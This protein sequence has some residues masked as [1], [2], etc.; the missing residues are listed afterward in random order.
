MGASPG[1][2]FGRPPPA[3]RP[4]GSGPNSREAHTGVC[5]ATSPNEAATALEITVLLEVAVMLRYLRLHLHKVRQVKPDASS[6]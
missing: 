2:V 5:S 1:L 4:H 6:G 3:Y